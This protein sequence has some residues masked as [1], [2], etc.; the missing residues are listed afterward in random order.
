MA[1]TYPYPRP[2]VTADCVVIR[3]IQQQSEVLLIRRLKEPFKGMWAL[4]GGFMEMDEL[5]KDTARRELFEEAGI[6]AEHLKFIG[7]FDRP[8]RD[9]RGRTISAAY[10]LEGGEELRNEK[11]GS[12]ACEAAWFHLSHLPSLAFDHA[13]IIGEAVKYIKK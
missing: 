5:L 7:I 8:G 4:P 11:P 9:P 12:D 6:V 3:H 2:S 13:E 1:Y 10:L